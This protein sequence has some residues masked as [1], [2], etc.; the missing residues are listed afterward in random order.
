MVK[1]LSFDLELLVPVCLVAGTILFM[2]TSRRDLL[3]LGRILIGI[4]LLILSL[5]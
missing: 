1:L 4:G 3:Q 2:A 5:R